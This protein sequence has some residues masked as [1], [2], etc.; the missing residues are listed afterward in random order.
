MQLSFSSV[1]LQNRLMTLDGLVKPVPF[2]LETIGWTDIQADEQGLSKTYFER[3][4]EIVQDKVQ[5]WLSLDF[6]EAT[7]RLQEKRTNSFKDK[8]AHLESLK[9]INQEY[10]ELRELLFNDESLD[11]VSFSEKLNEFVSRLESFSGIA[12][13]N[14]QQLINNLGLWKKNK[15]DR[16]LVLSELPEAVH[17]HNMITFRT[18]VENVNQETF[19]SDFNEKYQKLIKEEWDN[20]AFTILKD[21]F[22]TVELHIASG[23]FKEGCP[24]LLNDLGK[25]SRKH[26]AESEDLEELPHLIP[27]FDDKH[28]DAVKVLTEEQ[29]MEFIFEEKECLEECFETLAGR[30]AEGELDVGALRVLDLHRLFTSIFRDQET[31]CDETPGKEICLSRNSENLVKPSHPYYQIADENK[32]LIAGVDAVAKTI[33]NRKDL[34][35]TVASPLSNCKLWSSR[36]ITPIADC[37]KS[38]NGLLQRLVSTIKAFV[39]VYIQFPAA[40]NLWKNRA[41]KCQNHD[42]K[43]K[44]EFFAKGYMEFPSIDEKFSWIDSVCGANEAIN[45]NMLKVLQEVLDPQEKAFDE[46]VF[47]DLAGRNSITFEEMGK[48]R[49]WVAENVQPVNEE[50]GNLDDFF[51]NATQFR[52]GIIPKDNEA[53]L[54]EFEKKAR[55]V[56]NACKTFEEDF[57]RAFPE[58]FQA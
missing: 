49:E 36:E 5:I 45:V 55:A 22:N 48:M 23:D 52:L 30:Y 11:E 7:N 3:V 14:Y 12:K 58:P 27:D 15:E 18:D 31:A 13:C 46:K 2:L 9:G 57:S 56:Y 10:D 39:R 50:M 37:W 28:N 4:F 8:H 42:L 24:Q 41:A 54:E 6:E 43:A 34:I 44:L 20:D 38:N 26:R 35:S 53:P 33:L 32:V 47:K 51:V 19:G 17:G 16:T 40:L 21:L 25:W 1:T 29:G